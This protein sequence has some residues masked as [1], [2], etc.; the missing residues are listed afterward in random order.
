MSFINT[1][2]AKSKLRGIR[3][4]V[5]YKGEEFKSAFMGIPQIY[6]SVGGNFKPKAVSW[7]GSRLLKQYGTWVDS[8]KPYFRVTQT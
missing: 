2:Q 6:E 5:H 8:N 3:M 1:I 7:L 4:A